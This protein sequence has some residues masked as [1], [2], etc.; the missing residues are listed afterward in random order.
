MPRLDL[1]ELILVVPTYR[2]QAR[3]LQLLIRAA[4]QNELLFTPPTITTI[5]DLPEHLYVAEKLLA[6]DLA[7]Q[8][9]WS[10][11]LAATPADEI[12]CLVG[13]PDVEEL[14]DWQPLAI[15]LSKLH[16]RLAN[17]IWS[18]RSVAREV[19]KIP[20]FLKPEEDRWNALREIQKRYYAILDEV[21]LWDKQA[22]RNFAAYGLLLDKPEIR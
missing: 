22:A 19:K 2:A 9:A 11:A 21:D 8:I 15:V 17:D 4:E 13:R 16:R 7:Q 6:T 14:N 1:R 3:L 10:K 5:G 18:F 20:S 12:K